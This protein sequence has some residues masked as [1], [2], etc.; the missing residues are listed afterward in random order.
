MTWASLR[1][2]HFLSVESFHHP[3]LSWQPSQKSEL[4]TIDV[5]MMCTFEKP[6]KWFWKL[7][8]LTI[9]GDVYRTE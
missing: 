5:E 1:P 2:R 4:P 3:Q 6:L 9:V 7:I 8:L